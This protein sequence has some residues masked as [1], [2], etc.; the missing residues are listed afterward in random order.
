[1]RGNQ[2]GLHSWYV[3]CISQHPLAFGGISLY[4][5]S[6][7][8]SLSINLHTNLKTYHLHFLFDDQLGLDQPLDFSIQFSCFFLI[9]FHLTIQI[10]CLKDHLN[11]VLSLLNNHSVLKHCM[12]NDIQTSYNGLGGPFFFC[13]FSS[14]SISA[15]LSSYYSF[16]VQT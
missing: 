7:G 13:H 12:D 10:I 8:F 3:S 1:M 2:T 14:P 9:C 11:P 5:Q 15:I 4:P 6:L 16:H